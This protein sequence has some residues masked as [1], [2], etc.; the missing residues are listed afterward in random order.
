MPSA[1]L[2]S[3]RIHSSTAQFAAQRLDN[4]VAQDGIKPGDPNTD[5]LAGLRAPAERLALLHEPSLKH[6]RGLAAL[7]RAQN[8]PL[9]VVHLPMPHQVSNREW[10]LGRLAYG[11]EN[12]I[13]PADDAEIVAN[14]CKAYDLNCISAH[15]YLKAALQSPEKGRQF[16]YAYD[17]HPNAAGY[18]L[19]GK[20]IA[21]HLK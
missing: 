4:R 8:I 20:W 19:I 15:T 18:E 6:L 5:L 12:K 16:Y 1:W 14:L 9:I 17:F 3:L 7:A 2:Q 13:Y 11:L 10:S 21:D